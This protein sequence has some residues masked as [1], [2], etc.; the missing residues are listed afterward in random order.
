MQKHMIEFKKQ[1]YS[2]NE[3]VSAPDSSIQLRR[4]AKIDELDLG[5]V[6][7]Q[8][9]LALDITMNDLIGVQMCEAAQNLAANVG[10]PLLFE[11][12][13]L[14]RLDQIGDR[15]RATILHHELKRATT[16]RFKS[17]KLTFTFSIRSQV[18]NY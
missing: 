14:G 9:I 15:A 1:T 10:D 3:R 2:A 6:G 12:A 7:E 8:H 4:N 16:R 11:A 13:R 18:N 5:V 17:Q